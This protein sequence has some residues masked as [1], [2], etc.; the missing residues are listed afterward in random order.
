MAGNGETGHVQHRP[1]GIHHPV[2][3]RVQADGAPS[4]RAGLIFRYT[5]WHQSRNAQ[6]HCA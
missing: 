5:Q 2:A 6:M 3:G 1:H 4:L